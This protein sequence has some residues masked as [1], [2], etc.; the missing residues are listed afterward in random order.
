MKKKSKTYFIFYHF[1][2]FVERF[3][4]HLIKILRSDNDG[5]YI[6]K[7]FIALLQNSKIIHQFSSPYTPKQNGIAERNHRHLIKT[8]QTLLHDANL[9]YLFW[10]NA[11]LT[12]TYLINTL[13]SRVTHN[14][15][16]YQPLY[17]KP[18]SYHHLKIFGS[19]CYPLLSSTN[20]HKFHPKSIP[21]IFLVTHLTTKP[22]NVIIFNP[23]TFPFPSCQI[24]STY[25]S[26]YNTF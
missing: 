9:P 10:A 1:K 4:D 7:R 23:I 5:E 17:N 19:L 21:Y 8:T 18:L 15:S 11:L 14:I 22:K 6:S 3:F 20:K 2:L 16:P 25:F 13:A 24:S 12:A 26:I